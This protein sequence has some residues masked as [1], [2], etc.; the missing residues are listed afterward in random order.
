MADVPP[1][2]FI[3]CQ[4]VCDARMANHLVRRLII[5]DQ[6]TGELQRAVAFGLG[7]LLAVLESRVNVASSC[8]AVRSD[9]Q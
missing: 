3:D 1:Q 6:P 2:V 7:D 4:N 5:Q 8:E 9:D